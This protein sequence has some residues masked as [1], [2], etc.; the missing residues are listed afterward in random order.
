MLG[1][2]FRQSLRPSV[3]S[4]DPGTRRTGCATAPDGLQDLVI[5][6]LS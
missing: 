3:A 1:A 5:E 4:S 2:H 6:F